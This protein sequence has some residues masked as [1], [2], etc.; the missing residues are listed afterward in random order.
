MRAL[1]LYDEATGLVQYHHLND[2]EP[3]TALTTETLENGWIHVFGPPKR[4]FTDDDRVFTS[5]TFGKWCKRFGVHLDLTASY[6]SHQHGS[7]EQLHHHARVA[8]KSAWAELE[9][10]TKLQSL[11]VELAAAHN[12]L[13]KQS[14]GVSPNLLAFGQQRR[15]APHFGA[16][17]GLEP[18][19]D[20]LLRDDEV[21]ARISAV[22]SAARTAYVRAEANARLANAAKYKSRPATGPFAPGERVLVYR[23]KA[24]GPTRADEPDLAPKRGFGMVQPWSWLPTLLTMTNSDHDSTTSPCLAD[25]TDVQ[26]TNFEL[27]R[28][29][30]SSPE[31][32]YL[33]SKIWLETTMFQ[34]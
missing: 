16:S 17:G 32:D 33:N 13:S 31:D 8:M 7:I 15:D 6:A 11:C 20:T 10:D 24:L 12:D 28:P 23:T 18:L 1:S 19:A 29:A 3:T 22:R 25:S 5:K 14:T 30:P 4:L 26:N 21:Y 2:S 9:D 34:H 27:Y